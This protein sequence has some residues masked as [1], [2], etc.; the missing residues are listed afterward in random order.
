MADPH[1]RP[2]TPVDLY[3]L[4]TCTKL[5]E[6]PET[7]VQIQVVIQLLQLLQINCKGQKQKA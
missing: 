4:R 7:W 1:E 2:E 5:K 3:Y 6:R